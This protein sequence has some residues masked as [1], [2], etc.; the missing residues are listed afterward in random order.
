MNDAKTIDWLRIATELKAISQAGK[1][2]AKDE[3]E[4]DRHLRIE[5]ITAEILGGYTNLEKPQILTMLQQD[6]GYPSPKTDSR[7]AV[8]REDKILL[9]K[10][11]EDGLWTLPGGWCD[12]G[13]T[14]S[15]NVCREVWEESGFETQAVKLIA[16]LDRRNQGHLPP[17]PFDIYK[18]FFLCRI[19]GGS[20][21]SS[22]ET[23][24]VKF[25][26]E[27]EIPPLSRSRTLEHEIRMCF[28]HYRNIDL[29]T[30]YD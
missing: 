6:C 9:V 14:A 5:D 1:H 2:F 28:E 16:V 20:E 19:T 21:K 7:G 18:M 11:I 15:Q 12:M 17:Y 22:N 29:P 30:V 10:E 25:F 4:L 27:D 8:F 24:E 26:G 23:S 13:L 3:Y